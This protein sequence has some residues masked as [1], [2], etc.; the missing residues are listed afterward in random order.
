VTDDALRAWL[1][2]GFGTALLVFVG[3]SIWRGK[4]FEGWG[5]EMV[6][7]PKWTYLSKNPVSF[8]IKIVTFGGLGLFA[9]GVGLAKLLGVAFK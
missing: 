5:W 3:I 1:P 7:L 9:A 2:I 6:G 8:W 4:F